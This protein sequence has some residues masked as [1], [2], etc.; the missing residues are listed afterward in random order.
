MRLGQPRGNH[1]DGD[2]AWQRA[3]RHSPT[4]VKLR[5]G[6]QSRPHGPSLEMDRADRR[7]ALPCLY[8]AA[9]KSVLSQATT[10]DLTF[11]GLHSALYCMDYC[12]YWPSIRQCING[13]FVELLLLAMP[14]A[15]DRQPEGTLHS[16]Q[17]CNACRPSLC[18]GVNL[19][20][21]LNATRARDCGSGGPL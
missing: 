14:I 10:L 16:Q 19:I 13:T 12:I 8:P 6:A 17:Q 7:S 2:G 4:V 9:C 15:D 18:V 20:N 1:L 11:L 21:L 5:L 3:H